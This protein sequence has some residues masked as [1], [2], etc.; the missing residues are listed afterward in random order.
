VSHAP[1][2]CER[3]KLA[4]QKWGTA[5][6]RPQ[7]LDRSFL[8][9]RQRINYFN[10]ESILVHP[11][12]ED[13]NN[14]KPDPIILKPTRPADNF[15]FKWITTEQELDLLAL[16]LE[17]E[18][19]IA[20]D[21]ENNQDNSYLPF[22]CLIQ[23]ST[24]ENN[25]LIDTLRLY[26]CIKK[27]L[28]PIFSSPIILKLVLGS[29]DLTDLQRD[30][31]I[32][33]QAVVDL[34]EVYHFINPETYSIGFKSLVAAYLGKSIDKLPQVA[35]WRVRPLCSDLED[36]A[37]NDAK[38]LLHCWYLLLDESDLTLCTFKRSKE[39]M[40]KLY[41]L[42]TVKSSISCWGLSIQE[43]PL[44]VRSIFNIKNQE[45]L[46]TRLYEWRIQKSK[47]LDVLPSKLCPND[48]LALLSRAK[49][50]TLS[51]VHSLLPKSGKWPV[52]LISDLLK[53]ISDSNI[54]FDEWGRAP[55]GN[56]PVSGGPPAGECSDSEC[57]FSPEDIVI[58][59]QND[60]FMGSPPQVN[61][62]V[63]RVGQ[64]LRNHSK[65][66]QLWH[67]RRFRNSIR[68]ENQLPRVRYYRN[69]GLKHKARRIAFRSSQ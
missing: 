26:S 10:F 60:R 54:Q 32:Y 57:D 27:Y 46:Y 62:Q 5:K 8:N 7:K 13:I 40:Q 44:N 30:F 3:K 17:L 58:E 23:I 41:Q 69:K 68:V 43:L 48:K 11:F 61:V 9:Y 18:K 55:R 37:V 12:H 47:N 56:E 25:F 31:Q 65:R 63:D 22:N 36:Y 15:D 53:L 51:N 28:G 19:V 49:P 4:N 59:V 6:I 35:D 38:L 29:T 24:N 64:N 45:V 14:W 39:N 66:N 34:Q 42:P 52:D 1:T 50:T 20:V 21:F 67:N 2:Y 33:C 16:D